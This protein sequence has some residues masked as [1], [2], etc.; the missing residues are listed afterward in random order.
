MIKMIPLLIMIIPGIGF[1]QKQKADTRDSI[2]AFTH[3]LISHALKTREFKKIAV[4]DF[5]D[6]QKEASNQGSYIAEQISIYA[7]SNDSITVLDRQNVASIIREH[8]MKDKD[9]LIDQNEFLELGHFSGAEVLMVGKVVIFET[10]CMLQLYLKIV[11]ANTAQTL[12]ADEKYISVDKQFADVAG[13]LLTCFGSNPCNNDQSGSNKK[14]LEQNCETNNTGNICI[15]NESAQVIRVRITNEFDTEYML[16]K[17]QEGKCIYHRKAGLSYQFEAYVVE[18][19]NTELRRE[20]YDTGSILVEKCQSKKYT[21]RGIVISETK[22]IIKPEVNKGV[23][24]GIEKGVKLLK[25][26]FKINL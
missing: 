16:L 3:K 20:I 25:E 18:Q 19:D 14:L 23:K 26:R 17:P 2:K 22:K 7:A 6:Q 10:E 15:C 1:A 8:R 12:A 5:T 13:L 11:D 4:W 21:I 9:H 24:N